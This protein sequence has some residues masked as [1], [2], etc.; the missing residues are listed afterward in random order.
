[1]IYSFHNKIPAFCNMLKTWLSTLDRYCLSLCLSE[2]TLISRRSLLYGVY[3]RGSK[4][5][6]TGGKTDRSPHLSQ[7]LLCWPKY[8]LFG[9]YI[10]KN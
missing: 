1:M 8:G 2:E 10:T 7:P 9:V 4:I 6:H 5:S 3:A